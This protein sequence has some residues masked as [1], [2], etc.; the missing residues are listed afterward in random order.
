MPGP[1]KVVKIRPKFFFVLMGND[2]NCPL[3]SVGMFQAL[4]RVFQTR[5]SALLAPV[6][7]GVGKFVKIRRKHFSAVLIRNDKNCFLN[8][9]GIFQVQ[10]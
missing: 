10:N 6:V 1:G 3:Q 9:V 2:K 5:F 7:P 8:N 4:N